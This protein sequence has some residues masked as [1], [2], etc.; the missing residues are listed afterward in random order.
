MLALF[1]YMPEILKKNLSFIEDVEYYFNFMHRQIETNDG[2][3]ILFIII[4]GIDTEIN[5]ICE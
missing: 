1:I 4:L 3:L 5:F 2:F